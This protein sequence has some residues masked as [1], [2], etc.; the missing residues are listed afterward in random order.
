MCLQCPFTL[1]VRSKNFQ[2][3]K[4]LKLIQD[5]WYSSITDRGKYETARRKQK[6]STQ[7]AKDRKSTDETLP[8]MSVPKMKNAY[9]TK[10]HVSKQ[11][12][13]QEKNVS[14]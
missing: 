12:R 1:P 8:K 11:M 14:M 3:Q 7:P 2:A 10:K 6:A 13:Q 9:N 4:L 5:Q